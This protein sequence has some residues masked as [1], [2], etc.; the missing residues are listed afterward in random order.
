MDP[1]FALVLIDV[2]YDELGT[3]SA[4]QI[5]EGNVWST[6]FQ[7]RALERVPEVVKEFDIFALASDRHA[8]GCGQGYLRKIGRGQLAERLKVPGLEIVEVV[9][10]D[11]QLTRGLGRYLVDRRLILRR[12]R[13]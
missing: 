8:Q 3:K 2:V 11:L 10:H 1:N 12:H 5:R 4:Y 7:G 13:L 6:Y 9:E